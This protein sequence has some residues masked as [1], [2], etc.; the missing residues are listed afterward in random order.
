MKELLLM[1]PGP[2]F[3]HP[4]VLRTLSKPM[5]PHRAKEFSQMFLEQAERLKK[6]FRTKNEMIILSGS[7][8]SG[9]DAAL[10]SLV[11]PSD[12][13]LCVVSG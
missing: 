10:S 13:V 11:K 5:T 7:G 12:E 9:M 8:T 2:T 6:V 3:V 4:R 1:I